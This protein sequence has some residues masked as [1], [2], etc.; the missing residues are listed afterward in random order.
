MEIEF[1]D[2]EEHNF[3]LDEFKEYSR[4]PTIEEKEFF[5]EVLEELV[6]E[7][8][9]IT[10]ISTD[11][12]LYFAITEEKSLSGDLPINRFV[13]G[14][15]FAKWMEGFD[16][17]VIMIRAVKDRDNWEDC[18]ANMLA[19]EMAHQEYYDHSEN[20]PLTNLE[21]ILIEG[22][23]MNRAEQVAREMQL[24]WKP[25][26]RTENLPEIN[27][28]TIIDL[29]DQ[30]RTYGPEDIFK[31]GKDPCKNAEGYQIAYLVIKD[32]TENTT[33]TLEGVASEDAEEIR[34]RVEGSL[35][36]LLV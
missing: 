5:H 9:Q 21:N 34:K 29:L 14:Y 16:R 33:L 12:K 31:N 35:R 7:I 15:S 24:E 25:H 18:L 17:D 36:K 13:H 8:S 20:P 10:G 6:N 4:E 22:H 27:S 26:Y 28:E 11:F 19:H 3:F 23:A 2:K 32:L 1:Y 30:K